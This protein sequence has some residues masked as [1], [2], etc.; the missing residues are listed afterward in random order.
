MKENVTYQVRSQVKDPVVVCQ[1]KKSCIVV[2]WKTR[3]PILPKD[4]SSI[5]R[6]CCVPKQDISL[7]QRH[8][9]Q[10]VYTGTGKQSPNPK[11]PDKHPFQLKWGTH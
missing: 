4:S 7:S 2:D 11:N 3:W 8:L 5:L 10:V 9:H 1:L 6:V